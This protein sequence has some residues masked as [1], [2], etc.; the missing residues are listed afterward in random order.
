MNGSWFTHL[1]L[2]TPVEPAKRLEALPECPC[3]PIH[4]SMLARAHMVCLDE[5]QAT[6][7]HAHAPFDD[8][9]VLHGFYQY[10]PRQNDVVCGGRAECFGPVHAEGIGTGL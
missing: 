10:L 7:A 4:A 8:T 2:H 3:V 5:C 6:R 1:D 9:S